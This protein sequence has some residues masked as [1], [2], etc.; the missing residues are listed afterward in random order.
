MNQIL[1]PI[2]K[3]SILVTMAILYFEDKFLIQLRDDVPGI[4][5][6]GHWGLF[7]GHLEANET[8]EEAL[9][10]ELIEEI[11]YRVDNLTPFRT[12]QEGNRI[13]YSFFGPLKI[14]VEQI[15]L[16]EGWDFALVTPEVI[17]KGEHFSQVAR[18]TYPLVPSI[19]QI[20]LDFLAEDLY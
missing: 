1:N 5:Y 10:R 15:V 2:N 3:R 14:P 4:L 7:G 12:Y 19:R 18:G 6:P 9:K 20:L 17:R 13:R 8:P 11:G 16:G